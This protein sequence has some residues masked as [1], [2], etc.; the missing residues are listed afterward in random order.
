VDALPS[1]AHSDYYRYRSDYRLRLLV[2][3]LATV[4]VI[5]GPWSS[6]FGGA[7]DYSR[8]RCRRPA[9]TESIL[10]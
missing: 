1:S 5:Y 2:L 6:S 7:L 4:A 10:F 8:Y 3:A 9:A